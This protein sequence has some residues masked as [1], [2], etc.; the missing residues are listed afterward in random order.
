MSRTQVSI[1]EHTFDMDF[2]FTL[3]WQDERNYRHDITRSNLSHSRCPNLKLMP[4]TQTQNHTSP[5]PRWNLP[6]LFLPPCSTLAA[7]SSPILT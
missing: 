3:E 7:R 4:K 6:L 2:Y 1:E 5:A